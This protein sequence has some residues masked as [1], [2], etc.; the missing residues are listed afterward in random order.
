MNKTHNRN[1]IVSIVDDDESVLVAIHSLVSSFG[2][3]ACMFLSAETFL[4]SPQL[5]DT[6]CLISD[7]HMPSMSG[8]ELQRI[9]LERGLKIFMTAFT[10]ES[11]KARAIAGGAVCFLLKPLDTNTLIECINAALKGGVDDGDGSSKC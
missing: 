1:P 7:V 5:N 11:I 3:E 4:Q 8:I 10:N 2:F 6:S 9:L